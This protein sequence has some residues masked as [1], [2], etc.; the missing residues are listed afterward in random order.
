MQFE[1]LSEPSAQGNER[2][3]FVV[4]ANPGQALQPLNKVASGGE[5]SRISL[6]IQ[7]LTAQRDNTP[8]LIFDEVDVG[9]GGATANKIGQHLRDLSTKAQVLCIT[10]LPQVAA[11]AEQQW[12]VQKQT[13]AGKTLSNILVL[14][15][16]Q[17][18]EEIARM[19]GGDANSQSAQQ[20]AKELLG[21]DFSS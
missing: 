17:R 8:T 21:S 15:P 16:T 7:L 12:Q 18:I 9:I 14:N 4:S 10:H 19:L 6:A 20:H 2:I 1:P 13:I 3:E 11:C 5:L